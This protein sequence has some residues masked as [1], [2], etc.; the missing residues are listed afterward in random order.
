MG[1]YYIVANDSKK[2]YVDPFDFGDPIKKFGILTGHHGKAIASLLIDPQRDKKYEEGYWSGDK[3]RVIGDNNPDHEY[4]EDNYTNISFH[5]IA[6]MMYWENE[7]GRQKL[8]KAVTDDSERL[9]E[10]IQIADS[11]K[12]K[13]LYNKLIELGYIKK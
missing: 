13:I 6:K 11:A 8:I 2:E 5:L 4:V 7:E 9:D 3:I 1:T 12:D 10:L